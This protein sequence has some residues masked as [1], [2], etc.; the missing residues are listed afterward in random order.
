MGL[1]EPPAPVVLLRVARALAVPPS[2]AWAER[3]WLVQ[4]PVER[5]WAAKPWAAQARAVWTPVR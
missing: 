1:A 2:P 5:A 4:A 3:R